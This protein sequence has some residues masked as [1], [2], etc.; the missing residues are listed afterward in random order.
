MKLNMK[1][2]EG[3]VHNHA[4][5][6]H[7]P[8][9]VKFTDFDM[10]MA[11]SFDPAKGEKGVI[12]YTIPE[13]A[14]ISI[15]VL[16]AGTRELF[17]NTILNWEDREAGTHTETW[18]GRDYSGNIIDLSRAFIVIEGEPKS[19]YAPGKYSL[20]GMSDEEIIHGHQWGHAHNEYEEAANVVPEIAMTSIEDGDVLS[21]VVILES[22]VVSEGK[23][24]GN[25]AGYGVRYY[26]D[27]TVLQEEFY[28]A[29]S[30]GKFS[31][32]LDTTAVP[33]GEYT[34]YVGMCD[35]HQHVTSKSY[36]VRIE[37]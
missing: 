9:K 17:L 13:P 29:S 6:H 11:F 7:M 19:T 21:G 20:E 4:S 5:H 35:H 33:N 3:T 16:M 26:M 27:N 10:E 32:S 37:N 36:K 8:E 2:L 30:Q 23:G 22:E 28:D 24:Y 1:V 31:Y 34:L 15:K 14:R 18:D 12:T 25:E